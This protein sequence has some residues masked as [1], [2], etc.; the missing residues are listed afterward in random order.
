MRRGNSAPVSPAT[1]SILLGLIILF[2]GVNWPVMKIGLAY[3]GPLT[4]AA[5]RLG[6][7]AVILFALLA[8]T[9]RLTRPTRRDWP[10]VLTVGTLQMAAFLGLVTV[11]LQHV[12][13]GRSAILAYTTPLWVVPGAA[14]FL[15]E[16]L[17]GRRL[18]G[19]VLG[20]GGVA[21]LFNPFGFDWSAPQVVLG[22]G[23]LMLAA[24]AWAVQIVQI[25]G[26]DWDSPPLVLAPWQLT[27]GALLL[28][29]LAVALEGG[30]PVRWTWTLGAVLA[31][32]GIA[33]TAFCYVA[34]ITVNRALPAVTTSLALLAVPAA[35]LAFSAAL[36]G[37]PVGPTK[38]AG[39][40]LIVA[41]L[42][43]VVAADRAAQRTAAAVD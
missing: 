4:F 6:L 41:G 14:L 38:A 39:L 31:F 27:I 42:A 28:A 11:G 32:N 29:P 25:R 3:V 24:V 7:A 43:L 36:L 5:T 35:G 19:F 18:A 13:A 1:A 26:H 12:D 17:R 20:M 21:V 15:G 8:A 40:G 33:A 2:W 10:I 9:G 16:Q 30:A 22:N 37:E 34:V 23:L